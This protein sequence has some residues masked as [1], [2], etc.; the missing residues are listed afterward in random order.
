MGRREADR[1]RRCPSAVAVFQPSVRRCL[2]PIETARA[3]SK[4]N[5]LRAIA[6]Y[7]GSTSIDTEVARLPV[8]MGVPRRITDAFF[9]PTIAKR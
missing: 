5:R 8:E 3:K 4:T 9:K 6:A 1:R 7:D 2:R